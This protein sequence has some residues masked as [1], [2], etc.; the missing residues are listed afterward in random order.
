M[1]DR[2]G[3]GSG[4][5]RWAQ[6]TLVAAAP[7]HDRVIRPP[8]DPGHPVTVT[9]QIMLY[10]PP[11]NRPSPLKVLGH[12]TTNASA[13][14]RGQRYRCIF[15]AF[16]FFSRGHAVASPMA[17]GLAES[18]GKAVSFGCDVART[19]LTMLSIWRR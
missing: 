5:N 2:R 11:G 16:Y 8:D 14:D 1:F 3:A 13:T 10:T 18:D 7:L 12:G 9:L 17:R 6:S 4:A 15:N 19:G